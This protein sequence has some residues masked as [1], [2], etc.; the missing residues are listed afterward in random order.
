MR[1]PRDLRGHELVSLLRRHGYAV[2]RQP[3]SHIRLTSTAKGK[4]HH[5]T[6]PAH[7]AL[8]VGTLNAILAEVA[9]YLELDRAD[10]A[11]KLFGG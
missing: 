8:S 7:Q 11:E 1:L 10:L 4:E 5:V 2:T 6:I 9:L 3:G